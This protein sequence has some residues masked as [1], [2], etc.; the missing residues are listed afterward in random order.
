VS[1]P[2][3][4]RAVAATISFPIPLASPPKAVHFLNKAQTLTGTPECPAAEALTKPQAEK[5][6]LCIYTGTENKS[7]NSH[8]AFKSVQNVA[9][10]TE[11]ASLTGAF[12]I[13]EA[14]EVTP[15]ESSLQFLGT[16]AVTG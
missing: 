13:F 14:S 7:S 3:K 2:G 16:W 8:V 1:E 15:G 5:G 6:V 9:G 12:V 11:K 4:P 10:E